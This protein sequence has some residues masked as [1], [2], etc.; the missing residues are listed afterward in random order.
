M[1]HHCEEDHC[2][3]KNLNKS[4]AAAPCTCNLRFCCCGKIH[5]QKKTT[6][7]KAYWHAVARRGNTWLLQS[8]L[9]DWEQKKQ[10][11]SRWWWRK[12]GAYLLRNAQGCKEREDIGKKHVKEC[13]FDNISQTQ[14]SSNGSVSEFSGVSVLHTSDSHC[15]WSALKFGMKSEFSA[16]LLRS[17][18]LK[19]VKGKVQIALSGCKHWAHLAPP[20]WAVETHLCLQLYLLQSQ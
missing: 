17:L 7:S 20:V 11:A 19:R 3:A 4:K 5:K 8:N 14:K 12:R 18:Q 2:W 10:R 16:V 15:F 1:W 9:P 13:T 6:A